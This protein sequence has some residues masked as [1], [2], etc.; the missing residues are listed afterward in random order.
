MQVGYLIIYF[1]MGDVGTILS[2]L[3]IIIILP[4]LLLYKLLGDPILKEQH[5]VCV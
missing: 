4:I 1:Q 2:I 3:Y 5:K